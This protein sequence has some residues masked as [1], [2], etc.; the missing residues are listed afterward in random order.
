[1]IEESHEGILNQPNSIQ[2]VGMAIKLVLPFGTNVLEPP[3]DEAKTRGLPGGLRKWLDAPDV[4]TDLFAVSAYLCKVGGVVGFFDP[5]PYC[6]QASHGQFCLSRQDRDELDD[7][8]WRWRGGKRGGHPD[9]QDFQ[10]MCSPS[11]LPPAGVQ[12]LWEVLLQAWKEPINCGYYVHN[13]KVA[14]PPSWW[15]ACFKLA[16]VADLTVVRPFRAPLN[17]YKGTAFGQVIRAL[18]KRDGSDLPEP[19]SQSCPTDDGSQANSGLA[20]TQSISR[21]FASLTLMV[22]TGVACVM[23][24]LRVAAVGATVRNL[25]RNLALLPGRG[26][27]RCFWDM[28]DAEPKSEDSETLD[29]LL[30]PAPFQLKATDFRAETHEN[31]DRSSTELHND[32]PNWESFHLTQSWLD[33]DAAIEN[34]LQDCTSLLLAAKAE[35][36]NVNAVI[37]PEYAL[38]WE[39][40]DRLSSRLKEHAADLEFVVAGASSN[41]DGQLSN[42]LLTRVWQRRQP[43]LHITNSRRKHHRWRLDRQQVETY[44]LGAVLN[45]KVQYWWESTLIG[46]RELYFHRFRK[47]S[48]FAA[49]ICEELARSD[50]CH[51]IL[52]AVGPNLVF[53][54]LMDT[55]Q[56]RERWPAQYAGSLADDPGCA[57]LSFTSYALVERS[58]RNR[59][60]GSRSVAL[61]KDDR[62][63]FV[64]MEIPHG[65]EPSAILLSLWSEHVLDQTITGKRSQVRAWR[66]SSHTVVS[67]PSK[68]TR[69]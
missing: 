45:P 17:R 7:I 38:T 68:T 56:I 8:A 32:K 26:E 16:M 18:L 59:K 28:T 10:K 44:G 5:S 42:T 29:I 34:F 53:A 22:D 24:K 61:W 55:A 60:T 35:T 3:V 27:M 11:I 25:S 20:S 54:L 14:S 67:L 65:Q 58:M 49:L 36:R 51:D 64:E 31:K 1:M 6:T 19:Q 52:R 48:A 50:V 62:N 40:F 9:H 39:V 57:V 46:Q 13:E 21:S 66:Y 63:K 30:I 41:C 47:D 2:T 33:N 4:A 23:P 37:L 69:T 12:V 43:V 15:L